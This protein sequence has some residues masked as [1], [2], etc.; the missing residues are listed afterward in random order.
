MF[1]GIIHSPIPSGIPAVTYPGGH[2]GE[3]TT[4][5]SF[6]HQPWKH[7]AFKHFLHLDTRH[8]RSFFA[9]ISEIPQHISTN[10]EEPH[11]RVEGF[12]PL[13]AQGGI[14]VLHQVKK[15]C[16]LRESFQGA[17]PLQISRSLGAGQVNRNQIP[18]VTGVNWMRNTFYFLW[19][20]LA[21]WLGPNLAK[22]DVVVTSTL[23]TL[24]NGKGK[25]VGTGTSARNGAG[26]VFTTGN[27]SSWRLNS[28]QL[29]FT[30]SGTYGSG[31]IAFYLY[32][33]G[34]GTIPTTAN[35][36]TYVGE[37]TLSITG[38]NGSLVTPTFSLTTLANSGVPVT[39]DAS[40]QY[41]LG[42]NVLE[43]GGTFLRLN[44]TAATPT[45]SNGW[46][47]ASS[48]SYM[49]TNGGS[50]PT[51]INDF[52]SSTSSVGYAYD[53]AANPPNGFGFIMDA[54]AV[55]EPGTFV[56]FGSAMAIGGVVTFLKRRKQ[57]TA[58]V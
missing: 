38:I 33:V 41:F 51:T 17:Q 22:A 2:C 12:R 45:T 1:P 50:A 35:S 32:K 53:S 10:P 21:L 54:T 16:C 28:I 55:P 15:K 25:V 36:L 13:V 18:L 42:M 34:S 8:S 23:S 52:S 37:T 39:L 19:T 40:T 27:T 48:Y 11:S 44:G 6:H 4:L 9:V 47:I 56:L 26:V 5:E 29:G 43:N 14:T 49:V 46:S 30:S 7:S 57:Q 31:S 20:F 58:T 24:S 3:I